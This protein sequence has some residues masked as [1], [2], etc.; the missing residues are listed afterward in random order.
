[1]S[2]IRNDLHSLKMYGL[3]GQCKWG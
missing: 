2:D 3:K 1:M